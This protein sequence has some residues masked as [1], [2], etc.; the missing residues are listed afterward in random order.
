MK[1]V[2]KIQTENTIRLYK[3]SSM[4]YSESK[5]FYQQQQFAKIKEDNSDDMTKDNTVKIKISVPL[6]DRKNIKELKIAAMVKDQIQIETLKD[7]QK[8]FDKS[9]GDDT[10]KR[11]ITFDRNIDIGM[12]QLGDRFHTCISSDDLNPP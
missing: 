8:E 5:A 4:L 1:G 9:N 10:I 11:I 12:I 6:S 7:V 2:Y 3:P